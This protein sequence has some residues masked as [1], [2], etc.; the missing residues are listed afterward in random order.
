MAI[1]TY[2]QCEKILDQEFGI[3]PLP[4]TKSLLKKIQ[5]VQ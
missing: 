4:E 1:K 5:G 2:K 3:Q